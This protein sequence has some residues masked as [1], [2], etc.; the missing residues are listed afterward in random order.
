MMSP[1]PSDPELL[2]LV[3]EPL[4]EDFQYWFERSHTLLSTHTIDFLTPDQQT[5]FVDRLGHSQQEVST[6][7]MLLKATA[8]QAGVDPALIGQWH[9]LLMECWS[10]AMRFR[11]EK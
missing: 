7:Q 8:G 11:Q 1:P 6:M 9:Q 10:I 3:L 4:L 5:A 2:K